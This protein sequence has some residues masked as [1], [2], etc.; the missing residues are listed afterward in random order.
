MQPGQ[1]VKL[2]TLRAGRA[3]RGSL[4]CSLC[5]LAAIS[6]ATR[7]ETFACAQQ[8]KGPSHYRLLG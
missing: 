8:Q 2:E 5:A 7:D 4:L 1:A 3:T 6:N